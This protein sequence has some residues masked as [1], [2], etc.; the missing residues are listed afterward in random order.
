[1]N[2]QMF[3]VKCTVILCGCSYYNVAVVRAGVS[4][5]MAMWL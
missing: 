2:L 3:P 4:V 1:M 5:V